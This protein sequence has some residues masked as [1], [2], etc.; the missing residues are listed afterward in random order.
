M[1]REFEAQA[2]KCGSLSDM[3]AKA[4]K[5]P[6]FRTTAIDSIS[7]VKVL[8]TQ[9]FERL[10][11]KGENFQAVTAA[12]SEEIEAL[13]SVITDIDPSVDP[14][15]PL[16]IATIKKKPK[17][18]AFIYHCCVRRHYFFEIKKCG[19]SDCDICEKPCLSTD[20]FQ[21][22]HSFPD[23]VPGTDGHYLP[24]S[25]GFGTKTSE[26]HR[27]FLQKKT[28][29]RKMLSFSFNLRH[30]QNV[31]MML[32]CDECNMWRLLYY[33]VKL[34]SSE[35]AK[36][37]SILDD[38]T[39]TCGASLQDLEMEGRLADMCTRDLSCNDVV[40]KLYY[41]AK[42]SSPVDSAVLSAV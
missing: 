23:P 24:F 31:N 17:L 1:D 2:A 11:L 25:K 8:L 35:K 15:E 32:Q 21:A 6:E 30:V 16:K 18:E 28:L 36:L 3:R 41:T 7:H 12:T 20:T 9:V 42:Y 37:S 4:V 40:E 13:W 27:P 10:K 22:L 29:R 33:Q 38:F 5:C 34:N 39:F 26:K 19:K 14:R